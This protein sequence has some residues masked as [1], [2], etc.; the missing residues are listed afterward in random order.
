MDLKTFAL[1]LR[2][3]RVQKSLS[4][5]ELSEI[6][7]IS[8]GLLSKYESPKTDAVPN[9]VSVYTLSKALNVNCEYL[10][11]VEN[12]TAVSPA[13]PE[14]KR[15]RIK[16]IENYSFSEADRRFDFIRIPVEY[17]GDFFIK[18]EDQSMYPLLKKKA[19]LFFK[20]QDF[21]E[22]DAIMLFRKKNVKKNI[23]RLFQVDHYINLR[24]L[25]ADY[26]SLR[27][28]RTKFFEQYH[29]LG[30]LCCHWENIKHP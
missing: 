19:T 28:K 30:I 16:K 13:I 22:D 27:F 6:T 21:A 4:Q 1:R 18:M 17:P 7:G 3:S 2:V 15:N 23:V 25:N 8:Q 5:K 24:P 14:E 10:L 11:G 12:K 29:I 26:V 20:T 9:A